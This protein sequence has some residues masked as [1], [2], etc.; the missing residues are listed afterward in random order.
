MYSV[1]L[2]VYAIGGRFHTIPSA[3][4]GGRGWCKTLCGLRL[5][6]IYLMISN[7]EHFFII[8]LFIVYVLELCCQII[9]FN[10]FN[11]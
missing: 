5:T 4:G 1:L 3:W 11:L 10:A 7:L 9:C 2:A 8:L 6:W